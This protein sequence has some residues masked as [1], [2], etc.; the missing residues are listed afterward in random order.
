MATSPPTIHDPANDPPRAAPVTLGFLEGGE[1]HGYIADLDP[2]ADLL[3]IDLVRSFG[4]GEP[5][6]CIEVPV[7]SLAYVAYVGDPS[8]PV[9]LE[10][11][12]DA[13]SL[14]LHPSAA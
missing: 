3:Q 11:F 2:E 8:A 4:D 7:A 14:R 5:R 9:E 6:T 13:V 12:V 1:R 10:P